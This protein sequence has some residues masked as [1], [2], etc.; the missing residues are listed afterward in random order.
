MPPR[1]RGAGRVRLI[2]LGPENTTGLATLPV[3]MLLEIT[4]HLK[5]VPVPHIIALLPVLVFLEQACASTR[6]SDAYEKRHYRYG[7]MNTVSSTNP[8]L[9]KELAKA[10]VRQAEIVTIRNPDLAIRQVCPAVKI[11][12]VTFADWCADTVYA[13]FA[14]CLSVFPNLETIQILRVSD[15]I[16]HVW[17]RLPSPLP[18]VHKIVDLLPHL[19]GSRPVKQTE[20]FPQKTKHW[21]TLQNG[22]CAACLR[23]GV[24]ANMWM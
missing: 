17:K 10:L 4:A 1:T 23:I 22:F 2:F 9:E 14:R 16:Y 11:V 18:G 7:G 6:V 20:A 15:C 13:E 3:E 19:T 21:L 12:T 24:R 5:T 8:N